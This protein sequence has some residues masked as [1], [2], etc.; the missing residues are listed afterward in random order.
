MSFSSEFKEFVMRGNVVD[1][2]VGIVIGAA[3]GTIVNSFVNDLLMPPIGMALGR[4]DFVQLK[5]VLNAASTAAD[6]KAIPEVAIRYGAFINT[7]INFLIIAFAVFLV[8]KGINTLKKRVVLPPPAAGPVT[9]ECPYCL[10]NIPLKARR[11][12]NCTSE[13][14]ATA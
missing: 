7:L 4:V 10:S 11:C 8:V 2:A 3:F 13:L 1:L 6:G 9:K 12:A 5:L 14:P